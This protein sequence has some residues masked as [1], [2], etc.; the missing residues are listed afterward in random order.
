MDQNN[1]KTIFLKRNMNLMFDGKN[2]LDLEEK[3][4]SVTTLEYPFPHFKINKF[5][6]DWGQFMSWI[7][8]V[9]GQNTTAFVIR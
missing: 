9:T 6:K 5:I 8:A 3:L 4:C 7:R 2:I 1:Q